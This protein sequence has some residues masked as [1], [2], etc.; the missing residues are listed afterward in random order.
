MKTRELHQI[1]GTFLNWRYKYFEIVRSDHM[2]SWHLNVA[3]ERKIIKAECSKV[4]NKMNRHNACKRIEE[5]AWVSRRGRKR[6]ACV[7]YKAKKSR[8]H[9]SASIEVF[10][11]YLLCAANRIN[12]IKFEKKSTIRRYQRIRYSIHPCVCV[13]LFAA[14]VCFVRSVTS[15][16]S[17]KTKCLHLFPEGERERE[18]YKYHALSSWKTLFLFAIYSWAVFKSTCGWL[19]GLFSSAVLFSLEIL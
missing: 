12:A 1:Y 14:S 9:R 10:K 8:S 19:V 4:S 15:S 5:V 18:V 17:T 3:T 16:F 13:C 11:L 2:F 6:N 7:L